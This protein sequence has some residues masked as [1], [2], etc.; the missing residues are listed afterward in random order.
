MLIP[1]VLLRSVWVIAFE[2]FGVSVV[3]VVFVLLV[4]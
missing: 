2:S 1:L 4:L 3:L